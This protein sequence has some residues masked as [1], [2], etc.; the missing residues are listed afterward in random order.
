MIIKKVAFNKSAAVKAKAIHVRDLCN[1][2]AGPDAGDEYEKVQHR[3]ALNLLNLDHAAQV[4][5]MADLAD[6]A[7]RSPQPVQHWIL[8]WRPG[9][10]PTTAQADQAVGILLKEMGLSEHQAIYALHRDT[11][12]CHLHLA[13]NR[14]HPETERVVTVNG[15]FDL[16]VAHRAIARIEHEQGWRRELGGRYQVREDG[17]AIRIE[18]APVIECEREPSTPARDFEN[19][20]GQKS[21]QRIAIEEA[22][23]LM[24]QA[25]SWH[26][27]HQQLAEHGIRFEKKGSGAV[28]WVGQT[29]VKASTA[30][31]DCS[32]SA[33]EKRLGE[34]PEKLDVPMVRPRTP[35]PVA[36]AAL[37][38]DKSREQKQSH[39]AART[40]A[41]R[42]VGERLQKEW[43]QMLERQRQ[44]RRQALGGNWRGRG[45]LL[46]A[47][48]STLAA[49]QA[50][51]KAALR[52]R[53]QLDRIASRERLRAWPT[54]EE[55]LREHGSPSLAEEWRHRDRTPAY[56]MG[57]RPDQAKARDIRSFEADARG[58]EVRYTRIGGRR[59]NPCFSDR[60]R[61][62][63]I[64]DLKRDSVLA[65]LQ[66]SAQKWGEFKVFGSKRYKRMCVELAAEHG[67]RISNPELKQAITT[68]RD[69]QAKERTVRDIEDL[70]HM[71]E[72]DEI[73][74][75]QDAYRRHFEDVVGRHGDRDV[76]RIDAFVAVRMRMTDHSQEDIERA[77]R[78]EAPKLRPDENRDW[79][80]YARRTAEY[81][82][83][84]AG[85]RAK[86]AM[87]KDRDYL[88]ELEGRGRH[89]EPELDMPGRGFSFW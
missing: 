50:Q 75:E 30:G 28:L 20:T 35:A 58:W 70:P 68:E 84:G 29:A 56:I 44:E 45:E 63:R 62:I 32:M 26:E 23:E 78:E 65:A 54:F 14:V 80:E 77:I 7:K 27:L 21:A 33:L 13:V 89:R 19:L 42:Q 49:R 4:Q 6:L 72:R 31:R 47:M 88:L 40:H 15:R 69:R 5:E 53:Q 67:F 51:E 24:R 12:N 37:G 8:S 34:F 64:H 76:S 73:T 60:G 81:A 9:E 41:R 17:Q 22:A 74:G 71:P 66:L 59:G 61:E 18:K 82:F 43:G 83:G 85:E 79:A 52:E 57:D 16:E 25:R 3:G 36:P 86:E 1:Y 2:I 48:R 38:W 46:N 39:Y 87:D 10:Q 55:W 11:S